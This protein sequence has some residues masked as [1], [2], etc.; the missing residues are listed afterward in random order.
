MA[1]YV[2]GPT[3]MCIWVPH[4]FK[5][6]HIH[7]HSILH[8]GVKHM[9]GIFKAVLFFPF[10]FSFLFFTFYHFLPFFLEVIYLNT[11]TYLFYEFP[12]FLII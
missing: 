4:F 9:L 5:F 6:I 10:F 8:Y 12:L 11:Y 1:A 3:R 7:K 2:D